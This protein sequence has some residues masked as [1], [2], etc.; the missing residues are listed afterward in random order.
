VKNITGSQVAEIL[1][2]FILENYPKARQGVLQADDRL[3]EKGIIDS[4]GLLTLID[5]VEIKF[6]IKISDLDVTEDKFGSIVSLSS[7]INESLAKKS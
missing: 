5:F 1:R 6:E 4:L 7:F 2:L 3:I